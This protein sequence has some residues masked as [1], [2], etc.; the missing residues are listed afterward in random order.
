MRSLRLSV[1]M[2]ETAQ[3]TDLQPSIFVAGVYFV[4]DVSCASSPLSRCNQ[5]APVVDARA[6]N[7]FTASELVVAKSHA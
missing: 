6:R 3:P 4:A 1:Y 2:Y 7:C 5:L